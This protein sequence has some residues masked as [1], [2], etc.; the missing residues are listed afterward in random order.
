MTYQLQWCPPYSS[1][2]YLEIGQ[3]LDKPLCPSSGA[4]EVDDKFSP[5]NLY[6]CEGY[7][8]SITYTFQLAITNQ[9]IMSN[10]H[11]HKYLEL[12]KN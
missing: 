12:I 11:L 2:Y 7:D 5:Q 6:W 9:E 4:M 3:R 10:F 1:L 8:T